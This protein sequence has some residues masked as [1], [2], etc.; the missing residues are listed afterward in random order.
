MHE[1]PII[2]I[3]AVRCMRLPSLEGLGR[4]RFVNQC[5]LINCR[6][7]FRLQYIC[8][9]DTWKQ[10]EMENWCIISIDLFWVF[11]MPIHLMKFVQYLFA[12][13]FSKSFHKKCPINILV[14]MY[15]LQGQKTIPLVKIRVTNILLWTL[16]FFQVFIG[17][18]LGNESDSE[19]EAGLT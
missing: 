12:F 16:I 14:L 6:Q 13:L 17:F 5:T 3:K 18:T 2:V 7:S 19:T 1:T 11:C 9:I 10:H 15:P 8:Q 4:S